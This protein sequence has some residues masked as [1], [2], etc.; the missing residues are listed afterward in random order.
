MVYEVPLFLGGS[1]KW[2]NMCVHYAVVLFFKSATVRA[3]P[4]FSLWMKQA[5][6][7]DQDVSSVQSEEL[8]E[9][10]NWALSSPAALPQTRNVELNM[11]QYPTI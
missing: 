2:I 8:W 3:K 10:K 11:S 9:S 7:A 4:V 1:G 6:Q 5:D